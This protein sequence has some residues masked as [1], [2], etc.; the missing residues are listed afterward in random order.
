MPDMSRMAILLLCS[1]LMPMAAISAAEAAARKPSAAPAWKPLVIP[2][3]LVA[4]GPWGDMFRWREALH[5]QGILYDDGYRMQNVYH[6]ATQ[7]IGMPPSPEAWFDYAVIVLADVDAPALGPERLEA[8]HRFVQQGGGLV[9]LGGPWAFS[10]GGYAG[11]RLEAMLPATF[12]VEYRIVFQPGGAALKPAMSATWW[13]QG[14]S[15][16]FAAPTATSPSQALAAAKIGTVPPTP[17]AFYLQT[18]A[19]RPQAI[20]QLLAGDKPALISGAFGNGRVVAC[21]LTVLGKPPSD[22][23]AFW[24]WD[25]WP[26]LLGRAI[27]WAAENRPL[28]PR[29]KPAS[30]PQP[31]S[32]EEVQRMRLDSVPLSEEFLARFVAAPTAPVATLVFERLLA[33]D[34]GK[35]RLPPPL[36]DA[37]ARYAQPAWEEP[38][39]KAADDLNPDRARRWAMLEL[40]GAT[41]GPQAAK[42][43]RGLVEDQ[44]ADPGAVDGLR[45]LGDPAHVPALLRVYRQSVALADFRLP[46]PLAVDRPTATRQGIL[47][48]HVAAALYGLG[49]REGVARMLAIHREIRLLRRI[50]GNAA[51][52]RVAD[53]DATGQG[54]RKALYDKR[55]D[56]ARLEAHLLDAAGPVPALQREALVEIARTAEDEADVSWLAA[57]L[58]KSPAGSHW[59]PLRQA[60]DGILRRLAQVLSGE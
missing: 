33:D 35:S 43:L 4:V 32:D 9:V 36:V 27:Q 24:D 59:S 38:L 46:D 10:R 42:V 44:I 47:A 5:A 28:Q 14:D 12:P 58:M 2:K 21:G 30:S 16:I 29:D 60:K 13:A 48:A 52:R 51:K 50:Y 26:K 6:G 53:L 20:V 11:T 49:D 7:M 41:R 22:A 17:R 3:A 56:F 40:L 15:P 25:E 31:P 19:P 1:A 18:L 54:I 23:L 39:R 55:E 57:A 8:I 37:L 45:R 34:K